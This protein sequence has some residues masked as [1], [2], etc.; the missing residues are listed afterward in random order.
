MGGGEAVKDATVNDLLKHVLAKQD[1]PVHQALDLL[2]TDAECFMFLM[3]L[4]ASQTMSVVCSIEA[5][6]PQFA[7]LSRKQQYF[8]VQTLLATA[9][10][11]GPVG[12]PSTQDQATM[13]TAIVGLQREF[14]L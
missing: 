11:S 9:I 10:F 2:D 1:T 8:V 3:S 5:A 12:A 6:S 14:G 4:L 13:A 7:K